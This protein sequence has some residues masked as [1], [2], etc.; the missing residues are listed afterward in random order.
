[1]YNYNIVSVSFLAIIPSPEVS[2]LRDTLLHLQGPSAL[3]VPTFNL[4]FI[5]FDGHF[6]SIA[7]RFH[8]SP[9]V[10]RFP[11]IKLLGIISKIISEII[12]W[13]LGEVSWNLEICGNGKDIVK[14]SLAVYKP[15]V[16][17][18]HGKTSLYYIY[19]KYNLLKLCI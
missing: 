8:K 16:E 13:N 3:A 15:S 18:W 11:E 9:D 17:S 14:V 4:G 6:W 12:Y 2:P 5:N 10:Q 19:N 1:M 7:D